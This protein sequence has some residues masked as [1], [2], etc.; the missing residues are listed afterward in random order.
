MNDAQKIVAAFQRLKRGEHA[1]LATVVSVEGSSYT[2][3]GARML[4]TESG[5]TT[6]VL[7]A[8]CFERDVCQR[9]AKVMLTGEPV[10]ATYDTTTDEDIVWDLGLG[11]NG[12]VHVLI[13]PATNDRVAGL[14]QLLA[15]CA[16]SDISGA[17]TTVFHVAGETKTT[18]GTTVLL[19]PDGTIDGEFTIPSM[20]DDLIEVVT[21]TTSTIKRYETADGY[22]DVFLEVIQPR[23][24]L[25]IFGGGFDVLPVAGLAHRCENR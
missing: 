11:C 13:E 10:L 17:I 9:A 8:G 7:S 12:V 18:I 2:R 16:E 25:V 14:M 1:A 4:I 24:R 23:L 21:T 20:F 19:Y 6:G 15:E 22:V 3:P 5:E